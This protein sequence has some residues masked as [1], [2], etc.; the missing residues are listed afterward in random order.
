[1][2]DTA[3]AGRGRCTKAPPARAARAGV[4]RAVPQ[5]PPPPPHPSSSRRSRGPQPKS[6]Q[7]FALRSAGPSGARHARGGRAAR[8]AGRRFVLMQATPPL[9]EA[10]AR[11]C[12]SA[13]SSNPALAVRTPA[14]APTTRGARTASLQAG[15]A[16]G[17]RAARRRPPCTRPRCARGLADPHRICR[18]AAWRYSSWGQ[19]ADHCGLSTARLHRAVE[20]SGVVGGLSAHR[21]L[22]RGSG[23]RRAELGHPRLQPLVVL[24][25]L[26]AAAAGHASGLSRPQRAPYATDQ[27]V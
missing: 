4:G 10:R 21:V 16:L 25:R 13:Q 3:R 18:L 22:L 5:P 9:P 2:G 26:C 12:A 24:R 20:W 15:F 1:V 17:M 6:Q 19:E 14:S 7:R 11:A 27:T 8:P 23:F